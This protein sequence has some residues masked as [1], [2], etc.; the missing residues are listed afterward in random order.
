M[1]AARGTGFAQH[2]GENTVRT[3]AMDST[4]GL[5]RGQ[6]VRDTLCGTKALLRGDYERIAAGRAY[7]GDFD[8]FG[9]FEI[10]FPACIMGSV[11]NFSATFGMPIFISLIRFFLSIF[12]SCSA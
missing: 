6:Q 10:L 3:I 2:L 7:F 9:D 12:F 1:T 11:P 8:P 4:D 5:T